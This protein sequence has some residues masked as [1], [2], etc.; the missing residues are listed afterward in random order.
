[1]AV[2]VTHSKTLVAPDSGVE[3][4]IYGSDYVAED[5]HTVT[6]LGDSAE[7]NVGTAAGT[8]AAGD[9]LHTGVYEPAGVAAAD[10]TDSSATGR[11]VLT[12][13]AAAGRT[14]L[15]ASEASH[16]HNGLAPTA[17]TTGQVLKKSSDTNFDYAWAADATS[18]GGSEAFPVGSVF[19]SV[20]STDPATLL[21][22]GTWS[23][24]GAGRVL[25]GLD[26]GDANF[27]TAEETGGAKT[28]T[29]T[30]T[31]S[32]PTFSGNAL[33]THAHAA[34]TLVPDAHSATAVADH[35]SHTH[36][37][38]E[39]PNHVHT[40]ATGTGTTGNFSQVIGTVDTSSGGTGA[41]PTQ[42]TLGTRTVATVSGVATGT[43]NGPGAALTH[44][45]TQ[46][47]THTM[48]GT[49]EAVSAGTPAGTVTQ[50]TYTGN[51]TSVVQPYIVCYF[52]KRT[53]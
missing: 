45:V 19:I 44:S 48:S 6:G 11:S 20:V 35:A 32:Q 23:A 40:L 33:G 25:V 53:A 1:M 28:V 37:Y 43:T 7:K 50:P 47:A 39:V 27:D 10:I 9:H 13:D 21:G 46:P 17:G 3:D 14:A 12:G 34:G 22:Y 18:E 16:T 2:S 24:F 4:K 36:T 42:T 29:S 8:V 41:T 15:S 26:S 49:S 52:W 38:T 30:G 5:S 51:A 31:V